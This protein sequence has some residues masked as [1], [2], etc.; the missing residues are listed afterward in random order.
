KG[1]SRVADYPNRPRHGVTN[2]LVGSFSQNPSSAMG[3]CHQVRGFVINRREA[4]E[5]ARKTGQGRLW[6]LVEG[7]SE[8]CFSGDSIT[9]SGI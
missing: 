4:V 8:N 6:L 3:F 7:I 1:N 2:W 5:R 9:I